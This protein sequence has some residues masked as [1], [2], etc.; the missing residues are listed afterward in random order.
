MHDP[1]H[2]SLSQKDIFS[3]VIGCHK[4]KAIAMALYSAQTITIARHRNFIFT[5]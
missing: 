4:A 2:L 3:A 1:S 5:H